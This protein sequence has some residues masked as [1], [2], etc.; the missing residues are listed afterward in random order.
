MRG[1]ISAEFLT[2]LA[3][4]MII[5]LIFTVTYSGQNLNIFHIKE[6]LSGRQT[7]YSVATAINYVHL[8]GDGAQYRFNVIGRSDD[9][10]ITFFS[11]SV[12]SRRGD[13]VSSGP[14]LNGIINVSTL[15]GRLAVIRNDDGVIGIDQ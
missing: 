14:L 12:E 13:E 8:A 11:H 10:N 1:N 3:A 5:F 2:I 7:A 6:M 4:L 9:E 15:D